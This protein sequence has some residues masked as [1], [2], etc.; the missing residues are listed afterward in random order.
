MKYGKIKE[1]RFIRRLNRF[2]A[3]VRLGEENI[4]C[5]VKNTGR[6]RELL[7]EGAVV[8]LEDS[9]NTARKYPYSLIAVKK[10]KRLVNMDSQAPNKAVG[11]W[12]LGGGLFPDVTL[13]KAEQTYG[14]SRFDF[15]CEHGGKRAFIEVKGV[16]LERDGV[17]LFP[18]APTERGTKHIRELIRCAE[19]G[20]EAYLVFVVQMRG[21]SYFRPNDETD[22]DFA[23]ALREA[24]AGSVKIIALDCEVTPDSMV[25]RDSVQI[26]LN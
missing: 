3:E 8:Y 16:T 11:E 25:I 7:T 9:G 24:A 21:V 17:V 14:H 2:V 4:L 26:Q 6:C 20:Y 1:A 15:A 12:L 22:P 23:A 19:E 13:V 10:G 5:H 18:D